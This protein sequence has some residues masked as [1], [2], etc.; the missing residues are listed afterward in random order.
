MII[1]ELKKLQEI[2]IEAK[3]WDEVSNIQ[4]Q[5]DELPPSEQFEPILFET[6]FKVMIME[7]FFKNLSETANEIIQIGK[8]IQDIER[9]KENEK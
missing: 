1:T 9:R 4:Y 8:L 6:W 2:F 5:I 3:D 7:N